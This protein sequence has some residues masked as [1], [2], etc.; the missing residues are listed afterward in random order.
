MNAVSSISPAKETTLRPLKPD[1]QVFDVDESVDF[2]VF[3][4]D[5][6]EYFGIALYSRRS[7]VADVLLFENGRIGV[8]GFGSRHFQVRKV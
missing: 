4:K 2:T 8:E 7:I 1:S 3:D 5:V 6:V